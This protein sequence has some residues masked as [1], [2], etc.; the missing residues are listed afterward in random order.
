MPEGRWIWTNFWDFF[1][2]WINWDDDHYKKSYEIVPKYIF[3]SDQSC[4][5]YFY[6]RKH[7]MS[8]YACRSKKS[9]KRRRRRRK[10]R[11]EPLAASVLLWVYWNL[12]KSARKK[13]QKTIILNMS[14]HIYNQARSIRAIYFALF[15]HFY[16]KVWLL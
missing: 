9:K 4:F 8:D 10:G 13:N 1:G 2:V 16:N 6:K 12:K 7:L 11:K 14:Y 15:F 5:F 3:M